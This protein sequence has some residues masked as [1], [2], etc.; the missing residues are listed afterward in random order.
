MARDEFGPETRQNVREARRE[1]SRLNRELDRFRQKAA[2]AGQQGGSQFGRRFK[3]AAKFLLKQGIS[4]LIERRT[5]SAALRKQGDVI[6]AEM[7]RQGRR[8]G[9]SINMAQWMKPAIGVAAVG[10]GALFATQFKSA[11]AGAMEQER[12][13]I[14]LDALTGGRGTTIF[15][16]LRQEAL[17]TGK[18]VEMMGRTVTKLIGLGFDPRGALDLNRAV[19]DIAGALG[20][21]ATEADLVVSALGQV[22]AKGKV[23]MEELRQQIGERAVPIL[24]ELR[25]RYG[26]NWEEMVRQGKIGVDE[27]MAIFT[28]LEGELAKFRGG[29]DRFGGSGLGLLGR[30]KQE[31]LDLKRA[32]GGPLLEPVKAVLGEAIG[33]VR[34]LKDEARAFGKFLADGARFAL[35]SIDQLGA[36][37]S[38]KL[39]GLALKRELLEGIDAAARG[40][41]ALAESFNRSDFAVGLDDRMRKAA[42][43]FKQEM[44]GA[45]ESVF[46]A[47]AD[48]SAVG[49]RFGIMAGGLARARLRAIDEE[50]NAEDRAAMRPEVDLLKILKGEFDAFDPGSFFGLKPEDQRTMENLLRRV[51]PGQTPGNL[52]GPPAPV[53]AGRSGDAGMTRGGAPDPGAV[54]GGGLATALNMIAGGGTAVIMQKQADLQ[55]AV[56][57]GVEVTNRK[58]DQLITNTMPRQDR[59]P[60]ASQTGAVRFT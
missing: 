26:E 12:I 52:Y 18:D 29:A 3:D 6:T 59:G 32:M 36:G 50:R 57:R 7:K 58:L 5:I 8:V 53:P 40:M 56:V 45:V 37:G 31:V 17:R 10:L 19:L 42:L 20:M 51:S 30:L 14:S 54:L 15:Q 28:N 1:L 35:A 27:V 49:D 38:L 16:E 23:A 39:L 13:Q 55:Q 22:Q 43:V 21:T 44:L 33:L 11:L 41:A 2:R 9:Q 48:D 34:G 24:A 46:R 60:I 47:M 4:T 25:A